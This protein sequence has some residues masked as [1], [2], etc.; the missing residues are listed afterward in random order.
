MN[1]F[2]M[3]ICV[4]IA[5]ATRLGCCAEELSAPEAGERALTAEDGDKALRAIA[6]TFKAHPYVRAKIRAEVEDLA[7]K[8][9]E[10]AGYFTGLAEH[11]RDGWRLRDAHW[12]VVSAPPP[13]R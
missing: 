8:R 12:S 2:A 11:G 13:V 3:R 10:E 1:E 5:L 7:G 4:V 9:V 6:E